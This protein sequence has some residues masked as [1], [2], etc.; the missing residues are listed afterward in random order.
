MKNIT[1]ICRNRQGNRSHYSIL[2]MQN[3]C[4]NC[5]KLSP[6][7]WGPS[8]RFSPIN[9]TAPAVSSSRFLPAF[10]QAQSVVLH[11][12]SKEEIQ[13][14][15]LVWVKAT[16]ESGDLH[17]RHWVTHEL[18]K[19]TR[20]DNFWTEHFSKSPN[21]RIWKKEINLFMN[22]IVKLNDQLTAS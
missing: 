6:Y 18:F 8:V 7:T 13:S 17:L 15:N 14:I 12:G 16:A 4:L 10:P 1:K 9:V 19:H 20:N 21:I 2:N 22:I 11:R 3:C 5:P